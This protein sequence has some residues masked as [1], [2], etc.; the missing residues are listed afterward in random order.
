MIFK[1]SAYGDCVYCNADDSDAAFDKLVTVFGSMP[2]QIV[3]I[4]E[5]CAIPPEGDVLDD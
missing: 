5:V 1:M 2:R 3:T 4:E